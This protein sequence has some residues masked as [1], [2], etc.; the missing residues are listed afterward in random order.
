VKKDKNKSKWKNKLTGALLSFLAGLLLLVSNTLVKEM[1]LNFVDVLF[2][3]SIVQMSTSLIM[4]RIKGFIIWPTEV[5]E[6]K[7]VHWLRSWL[8]CFG[9]VGGIFYPTNLIAITFMPLGDAMTI[10]FSC[11]LLVTIFAAIF[12]KERFRLYKLI[13]VILIIGGIILVIRPPFIFNNNIENI[14]NNN[15]LDLNDT[16]TSSEINYKIPKYYYFGVTSALIAMV[17]NA[18]LSTISGVLVK[19]KSTSPPEIHMVYNSLGCFIVSLILPAFVG[20]QRIVFPSGTIEG[21]DSW[22]WFILFV[23]GF[24]QSGLFFT[25]TKAIQF[26]G[27]VVTAF[28]RTSEIGIAYIIQITFFQT[29]IIISS[30]IG[31]SFVIIACICILLE[32]QFLELLHPRIQ[33]IF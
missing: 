8:I 19:N 18:M 27:P 17:F 2:I 3:T 7:N 6:D 33:N 4:I 5:D 12:F 22:S 15:T 21:Y 23:V 10:I 1:E 30:L 11:V 16:T 24:M 32:N 31:A 29:I 20:N 28:V 26:A 14:T 9:I 25:R 13:C